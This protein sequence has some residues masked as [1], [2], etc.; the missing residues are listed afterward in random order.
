IDPSDLL[1][2]GMIITTYNDHVKAPSFP[3]LLCLQTKNT[4]SDGAFAFIQSILCGERGFGLCAR[5]KGW[6]FHERRLTPLVPDLYFPRLPQPVIAIT[7]PPPKLRRLHQT[8]FHRIAMNIAQLFDIFPSSKDIEI[9][10]SRLPE[11][12]W[13]RVIPQPHLIRAFS[14]FAPTS[15]RDALLQDLHR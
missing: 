2:T 6:V 1:K 8:T 10:V 3:A 7:A 4:V 11:S 13:R 12:R 14:L 5:S 9:I 15:Q